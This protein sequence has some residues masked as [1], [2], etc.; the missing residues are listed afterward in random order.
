[1]WEQEHSQELSRL[2]HKLNPSKGITVDVDGVLGTQQV[3]SQISKK[4]V[5]AILSDNRACWRMLSGSDTVWKV[6]GRLVRTKPEL[7]TR[8]FTFIAK[9]RVLDE[10]SLTSRWRRSGWCRHRVEI[11]GSSTI[12]QDA[13]HAVREQFPCES[14]SQ[15]VRAV[16]SPLPL[17]SA[18]RWA[19]PRTT[20]SN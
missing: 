4:K 5:R 13:M 16:S 2:E 15:M 7:A 9:G 6:Y 12:D 8:S 3:L 20:E 10:L 17:Y 14:R 18:S 1:M 11:C 19:D